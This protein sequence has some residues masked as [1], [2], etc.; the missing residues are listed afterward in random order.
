MHCAL[1]FLA[2]LRE[3]GWLEDIA[4]LTL[5]DVSPDDIESL[6]PFDVKIYPVETFD[7]GGDSLKHIPIRMA[8]LNIFL[9]PELRAYRRIMYIDAD[10]RVLGSLHALLTAEF[11]EGA[12]IAL[13]DNSRNIGKGTF[14]EYEIKLD[15]A[16]KQDRDFSSRFPDFE[17]SGATCFFV[18][19]TAL[20]SS[21]AET[22]DRIHT[23]LTMYLSLIHI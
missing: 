8:K 1:P 3:S 20:L 11:P 12:V 6:A 5:P 14:Y 2:S 10:G 21:R 4:V 19:D 18:V 13:R 23:V 15:I 16:L 9:I 7:E 17:A 22:E